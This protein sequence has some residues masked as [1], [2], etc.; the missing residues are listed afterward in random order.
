MRPLFIGIMGGILGIEKLSPFKTKRFLSLAI[1]PNKT[2]TTCIGLYG[3]TFVP[4][5]RGR[6]QVQWAVVQR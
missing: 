2:W 4:A 3:P 1:N 6:I 5:G